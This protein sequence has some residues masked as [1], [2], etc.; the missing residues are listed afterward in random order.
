MQTVVTEVVTSL[1]DSILLAIGKEPRTFSEIRARVEAEPSEVMREIELLE[2][3]EL[4]RVEPPDAPVTCWLTRKP[5][6]RISRAGGKLVELAPAPKPNIKIEIQA[7]ARQTEIRQ[8]VPVDETFCELELSAL[9]PNPRNPRGAVNTAEQSF[10][11]LV[12]NVRAWGIQQPLVVTPAGGAKYRIVMG[13]RRFEAAKAAGLRAAPTIIRRF[14]NPER[15][16]A[17]MLVENIQ[18]KDLT[19]M[20]EARAFKK[21]YLALNKDIHSVA[22][23]LSLTQSYISQRLRLLRL[24]PAIQRMV[25]ERKIGLTNALLLAALEPEKQIKLLPRAVRLKAKSL[26]PII[27]NE[28]NGALPPPKWEAKKRVTTDEE[29]FTRS[30]AL[31]EL[32]KIGEAFVPAQF[33]AYAFDDVCQDSCTERA[34]ESSCAG[35]PVP[36]LIAAVLRHRSRRENE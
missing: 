35:C 27:E 1:R 34:D 16:E 3:L 31:K 4:F 18:R 36:R 32:G 28:K 14:E 10:L 17:A 29:S 15:E 22:R 6:G 2:N 30:W 19:P 20:Q 23:E 5:K 25:D 33:L 11:D 7:P 26:K 24:D 8:P 21:R 13:H 12:E 9:V